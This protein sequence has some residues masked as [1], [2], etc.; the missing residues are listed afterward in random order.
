MINISTECLK[1]HPMLQ[2]MHES[3]LKVKP[4]MCAKP[5]IHNRLSLLIGGN[6]I[7]RIAVM[8]FPAFC[9]SMEHHIKRS[10]VSVTNLC[11][12]IGIWI[13]LTKYMAMCSNVS[14][15]LW[16][17]SYCNLLLKVQSYYSLYIKA[18]AYASVFSFAGK[19]WYTLLKWEDGISLMLF[20][21]M[22]ENVPFVLN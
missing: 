6:D 2:Q 4:C 19:R 18:S 9:Q 8:C 11:P 20:L 16:W 5:A 15:S 3:T 1:W 10:V 13:D 22:S 17:N 7:V 14:N 12:I 21:E